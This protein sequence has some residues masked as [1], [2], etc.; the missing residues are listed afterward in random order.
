MDNGHTLLESNGKD[1]VDTKELNSSL[2]FTRKTVSSNIAI[3]AVRHDWGYQRN[4]A[5]PI[6]NLIVTVATDRDL[7]YNLYE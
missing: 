3:L 6:D 1:V 2:P 7:G 4:L 5:I